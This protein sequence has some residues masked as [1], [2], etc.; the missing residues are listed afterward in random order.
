MTFSVTFLYW[1][2]EIVTASVIVDCD[3]GC[4]FLKTRSKYK[5]RQKY[6]DAA[7]RGDYTTANKI[8]NTLMS[9]GLAYADSGKPMYT[10]YT[11]ENW[12]K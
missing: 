12:L 4:D 7:K 8:K 5:Y 1:C 9:L 10:D 3:F 2:S 6:I 11:F